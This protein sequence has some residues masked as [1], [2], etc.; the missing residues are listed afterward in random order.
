MNKFKTFNKLTIV[1]LSI[2]SI[3]GLNYSAAPLGLFEPY[4]INIKLK[5]PGRKNFYFGIMGEKSYNVKGYATDACE[6]T[7][8]LVNPL[9]IYETTTHPE[10][11][12]VALYQSADGRQALTTPFTQLL[13]SIAGGPGSGVSNKE[14][15]L[16]TPT[17]KFCVGQAAFSTLYGVGHGIYIGA[18]L[19]VY[20]VKLHNVKWKYAGNN[21]LFSGEAIQQQMIDTFTQDAKEQFNLDITGWKRHGV[22][23]L[24]IMAEW[25]RDFPQRRQVLKN[26]TPNLRLGLSLPTGAKANENVLFPVAFGSDGAFGL[27]FGG[28]L[29]LHL[30]NHVEIG[31]SGQFWHYFGH[32]KC[33][34]VKTFTTQTSLLLPTVTETYREYSFIQ[35]FNLYTQVFSLCKRFSLKGIY[36]YWRRGEDILTPTDPNLN[37]SIINTDPKLLEQTRHNVALIF[38]YSPKRDDFQRVVPQAQLFWKAAVK[39]MRSALVSTA[40]AQ[41]SLIF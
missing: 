41:L 39:G 27:P 36:Q 14:N 17:G 6:E 33:R 35:N 8:T 24:T 5:R 7:T 10:Q 22:G 4:D 28:G 19:P 20:F 18:Y 13:D 1:A 12:W 38:S 23:D 11:N 16:F 31:F 30:G 32:Q 29:G 21:N 26:V 25:Q 15:G 9:Q 3:Y 2:F 40:G 37:V 34:R